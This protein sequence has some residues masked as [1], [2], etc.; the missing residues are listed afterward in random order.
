AS[1]DLPVRATTAGAALPVRGLSTGP[2]VGRETRTASRAGV[3]QNAT[4]WPPPVAMRHRP[5][6]PPPRN[7]AEATI[8]MP[9]ARHLLGGHNNKNDEACPRETRRR[10]HA[11]LPAHE[12]L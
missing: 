10:G 3:R 1:F 11:A 4:R 5:G 12:A 2:A 7:F 8:Q 9:L 6:A